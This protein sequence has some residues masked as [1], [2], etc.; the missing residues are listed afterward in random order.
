MPSDN[1]NNNY[2]QCQDVRTQLRSALDKASKN[3]G[4]NEEHPMHLHLVVL[5]TVACGWPDYLQ[6][7]EDQLSDFLSK[8]LQHRN[9]KVLKET[10]KIIQG[11]LHTIHTVA[12]N[13]EHES[14]SMVS[15]AQ[16]THEDSVRLKT[17]TRVATIYLPATLI[18]TIFSSGLVQL[19]P[20]GSNEAK[21]KTHFV[22]VSEFWLYPVV[23]VVLTILTFII[24]FIMDKKRVLNYWVEIKALI[25]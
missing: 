3:Q 18:A 24:T 5:S 4:L 10:N 6:Y 13:I 7:L 12:C 23:T 1:G 17:L 22:I 16:R 15:V 9:A 19:E 8:I 14:S 21:R 2:G 25:R 11:H 20:S